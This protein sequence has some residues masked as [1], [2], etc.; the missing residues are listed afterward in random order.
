M[1]PSMSYKLAMM[2]SC[3]HFATGRLSTPFLSLLPAT[4]ACNARRSTFHRIPIAGIHPLADMGDTSFAL[5]SLPTHHIAGAMGGLFSQ[6]THPSRPAVPATRR[7]APEHNVIL[8]PSQLQTGEC[9]MRPIQTA[10]CRPAALPP[11]MDL[12]DLRAY[13]ALGHLQALATANTEND[14]KRRAYCARRSTGAARDGVYAFWPASRRTMR[15]VFSESH[16][17]GPSAHRVLHAMAHEATRFM[18]N[19]PQS[20]EVLV[21]AKQLRA[22]LAAALVQLSDS[23]RE[24]VRYTFDLDECGQCASSLA[25]K[26]NV[27]RSTIHRRQWHI[28]RKLRALMLSPSTHIPHKEAI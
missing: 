26:L 1:K 11:L 9:L 15:R 3:S 23:E 16:G 19:A 21:M 6:G 22:R 14:A 28:I 10:P 27:H 12:A 25:V 2:A 7:A 5:V 18:H 8:A 24:V 13:E 4:G 20:P 17:S